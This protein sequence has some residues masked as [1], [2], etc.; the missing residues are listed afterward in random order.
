MNA[1]H[2][3]FRTGR[4]NLSEVG[5]HF[6]NP[7]CFGEDLAVCLRKSLKE[8]GIESPGPDQEDWGWELPVKDNGQSYYLGV[9]GN[10][11]GTSTNPNEGEW[12]IIIEKRRSIRQRFTGRG[13]ITLDD[14][15][16]IILKEILTADTAI[17]DV[18]VEVV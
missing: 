15:V 5:A 9:G 7:C 14:K 18:H 10:A 6:I 3:L 11:D 13:K 12:R 4:F 1:L 8:K 16:A 17:R 2:L